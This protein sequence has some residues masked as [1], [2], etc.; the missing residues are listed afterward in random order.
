VEV[1]NVLA[2]LP[3]SDAALRDTYVFVTA[4]YDH[5]GETESGPDRIWNGANDDASGTATVLAIAESI[6]KMKQ[7]PRRSIVFAAWTAEEGGHA[8]S[9]FYAQHPMVPVERTI[10]NINIEQNGRQ[11]G[12]GG[13]GPRRLL[14]TGYHFSTL[15]D[16]IRN[17]AR[18]SGVEAYAGPN[19]FFA[20]SDNM[21][22]AQVGIPAHTVGSSLDFPDYHK[23]SDS[24]EKLDY[25]NM[26]ILA[27]AIKEVVLQVANADESPQW[28]ASVPEAAE[29]RKLRQ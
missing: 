7:R 23:P 26:A 20:Q 29:F 3:G 5:L 28:S 27:R 14:V 18:L 22:L 6:S 21:S 19:A 8:G 12:N 13:S 11:D 2:I 16:T 4:H 17:A 1:H 15:G 25:D 10:A 9:R 24:A